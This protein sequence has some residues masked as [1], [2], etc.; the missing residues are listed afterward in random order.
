VRGVGGRKGEASEIQNVG[1]RDSRR[2][3]RR[4]TCSPG[5][6]NWYEEEEDGDEE[7]AETHRSGDG[8]GTVTVWFLF[9]AGFVWRKKKKSG[10]IIQLSTL[11]WS[12]RQ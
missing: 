11:D 10:I 2:K 9:V 6:I 4:S 12:L 5:L 1:D 8:D 7:E 3:A